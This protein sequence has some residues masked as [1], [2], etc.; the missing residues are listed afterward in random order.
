MCKFVVCTSFV[1]FFFAI[2]KFIDS[3]L[4]AFRKTNMTSKFFIV[5][6]KRAKNVQ[7][8]VDCSY[9]YVLK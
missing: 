3:C 5:T 1:L 2:M 8:N 4:R 7:G 6:N 9:E